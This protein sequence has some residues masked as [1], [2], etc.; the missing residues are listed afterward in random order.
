[1]R[2]IVRRSVFAL[3][4]LLSLAGAKCAFVATSG[5]GSG[6]EDKDRG[7]GGGLIVVINDGQLVDGPV[8]GV[9]YESGSLSGFTGSDGEFQYEE[10]NT[11]RFSIGEIV[12]GASVKARAFMTPLDLVPGGTLDTPAVI[13]IAR[14]LQ[15]LDSVPGDKRITIPPL[16]RTAAAVNNEPVAYA[17]QSLDF[18]DDAAFVNAASQ[19]VATLTAGYGFTAVL[20]DAESAR[21]HLLESLAE[22]GD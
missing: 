5:S 7:G 11:I 6:H 12:L 19:L 8:Q 18:S 14:L 1:M 2:S 20:V 10:G 17:I 21:Q 16:L 4:V 13:N 15:S 9:R 22:S 3:F